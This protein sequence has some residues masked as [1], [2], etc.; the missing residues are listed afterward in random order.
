MIERSKK[1]RREKS[2]LGSLKVSLGEF[3][4][5]G[6]T[7]LHEVA[8][9]LFEGL[10]TPISLSCE[11]LLRYGELK[12]LLEKTIDPLM[13]ND[14][15]KFRDDYQA[16]S[17]LKKVPFEIQGVD[18]EKT[19]YEKFLL[20]E[21]QCRATNHR[22]RTKQFSLQRSDSLEGR[23][24]RIAVD[25]IAEVLGNF[26][27]REWLLS[28]RFGPG[29]FNHSLTRGT[30][31]LYDK[32]QVNPSVSKDME[33]LGRLLV[34]SSPPWARSLTGFEDEG[35]WPFVDETMLDVVP[36]NRVAFVPKNAIT[37]RS[38]AIEPL[39]NV[40]AQLGIGA[41]LRRRLKRAGIDLNDQSVNQAAAE[42]G[43]RNSSLATIDLSS[44][45]D[46]V[47]RE[48]V[49]LF[50]PDQWFNPM[51]LCRSKVGSIYGKSIWYEK[52]SSMGNGFTFELETLIF[53][54][55]AHAACVVTGTD[56]NLVS[57]YGDD[58]VLPEDSYETLEDILTFF[59]FSLNGKKSYSKGYFRE[60]CGKD[61]FDGLDV[62][63]FFVDELPTRAVALFR[64]ANGLR[65]ASY[66]RHNRNGCDVRLHNA[67]RSV[68]FRLPKAVVRSVR[69]PAHAGDSDGIISD[70]DE[71]Q[72]SPFV[73]PSRDGWEGWFAP[74]Y[75][76]VPVKVL[77]ESNFLG[78][79]AS[80]LYRCK[81]GSKHSYLPWDVRKDYRI[82][83]FSSAPPRQG[84]DYVYLLKTNA[85]YGNWTQLGPW[86]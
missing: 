41:M 24:Y 11:I 58:I 75:T 29:T 20:S 66:R 84:R 13:Y 67:W 42:V 78:A 85:F 33:D 26:S 53:K 71:A 18:R 45:S 16:V 72:A 32:L 81:D 59:G 27:S 15:L 5:D 69:V 77:Q 21:E 22:I 37:H 80:L 46:T 52:F 17:F 63:P 14:P 6:S 64:L 2:L 4:C 86:R 3:R 50:L 1:S 76:A 68:L 28:C 62:R 48:V 36:G 49:R 39:L 35:F 79:V 61:W 19:A 31:S 47:A 74:R 51:D 25:Y 60:S 73:V 10:S 54:S 70:W 82:E 40:Y 8:Q 43:S 55:L 57:V 65:R 38:I 23:A 9:N 44:A 30:S 34:M 56:P 12:Q 83:A 7:V